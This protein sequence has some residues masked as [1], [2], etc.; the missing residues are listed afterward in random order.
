VAH[1]DLAD[2][3][4]I[5]TTYGSRLFANHIPEHNSLIVQRMIDAGAVTVGK[6]NTPE[7]GVCSQTFNEVFGTT[8]NPYDLSK[9][10]GGRSGGSTAAL[11][12][13][14]VILADG[15]DMVGYSK[16]SRAFE[17]STKL[18]T[19]VW[20]NHDLDPNCSY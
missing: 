19:C 1:K 13:R 9:T 11:T 4:C 6:T 2:T 3:Q 14:L 17:G 10:T 18:E 12:A 15:S 7:F 8:Y 20:Q 5:R 16:Y